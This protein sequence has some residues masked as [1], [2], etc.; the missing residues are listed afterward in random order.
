M[1]NNLQNNINENYSNLNERILA[2]E[3]HYS[4]DEDN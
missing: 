3:N 1:L 4:I 2:L